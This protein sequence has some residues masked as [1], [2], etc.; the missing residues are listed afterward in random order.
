MAP[1]QP[2]RIWDVETFVEAFTIDSYDLVTPLR[3]L[4]QPRHWWFQ[5]EGCPCHGSWGRFRRGH[6]LWL[7]KIPWMS[8]G[9]SRDLW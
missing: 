6:Q 4:A 1:H 3:G 5:P 8:I 9:G 2:F 7:L